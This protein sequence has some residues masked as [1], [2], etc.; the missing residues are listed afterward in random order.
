MRIF[1]GM[2]GGEGH[3]SGRIV[4]DCNEEIPENEHW[5]GKLII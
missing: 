1:L 5:K 2:Q 4:T 3:N